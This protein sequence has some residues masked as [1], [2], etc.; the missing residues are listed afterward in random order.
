MTAPVVEAAVRGVCRGMHVSAASC[1][2]RL[3]HRAACWLYDCW[4]IAL[5]AVS[6][7][8]RASRDKHPYNPMVAPAQGLGKTLQ[9]ISFLSYL[10]FERNVAGPSLVVVPL[11]VRQVPVSILFEL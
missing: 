6:G 4:I 3:M 10:T 8:T 7:Y 2:R 11:S 9:T 1:A 5:E